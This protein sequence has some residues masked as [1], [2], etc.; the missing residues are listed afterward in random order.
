MNQ[1]GFTIIELMIATAVLSTILVTVTIVMLSIGNLYYKGVNQARVQD[2]TR[3]VVDELSQR[4]E[5]SS[6]QAIKAV[7]QGANG[8]GAYCI[9]TTRYTYVTNT[10]IGTP[11]PESPNGTPAFQHVLWRDTISSSDTCLAADLTATNPSTGTDV[12]NTDGQDGTELVAPNSRLIKFS[13][14]S[15]NTTSASSPYTINVEMGYGEND[16]Y[17]SPSVAGSCT[18]PSEMRN[19][20]DYTHGDLQCKGAISHGDQFCAVARLNNVTVLQRLTAQ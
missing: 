20:A 17:C 12:N 7:P 1:K 2:A 18:S 16:L 9:D 6:E 5:L 19:M 15:N 8:V 4:L 13:I 3:G 14:N 10:Q 11:P